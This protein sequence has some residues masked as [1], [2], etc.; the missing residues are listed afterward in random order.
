MVDYEYKDLFWEQHKDKQLRIVSE[1]GSVTLNNTDIHFE[2]F[3]LDESICS[4]ESII[5]GS[6]ESSMVKFRISNVFIPLTGK[7]LI[8]SETIGGHE[9]TPIQIGR[10]KVVSD[11]PTADKSHRDVTAYDEMT[12]ILGKEMA[13]WYNSILPEKESK[14]SMK[15]FRKSFL[16]HFG[17]EEVVPDGGLVNDG[18]IVERTIEPEQISGKDIITSICEIN[19]CFG[20]IG[21]DGKFHYIYLEQNIQGLYPRNDLYPSDTLYP[22]DP[23][24]TR[25]GDG[26]YISCQYEDFLVNSINKLQIRK[27]END[28]GAIIG[29]GDNC[30]IIENNFLVYGKGESELDRIG[31]NIYK[32]ITGIIYRPFSCESIGNPCFE[33]GDPIRISTKRELIETY[34]L[35]RTLRGIQDPRDEYSADGKQK[36]SEDNNSVHKQIIELKGKANILTRTVDETKLEMYDIEKGLFNTITITASEIRTE[37]QNTASGLS[38]RITQ[39]AESITAEVNRATSAEGSLS[40]SIKINADSITSEVRRATSA[41]GTLS[42]SI[43]Q[44]SQSI[45]LR[46]RYDDVVSAINM[47]PEQITIKANKISLEGA[48]TVNGG[49]RIDE[50]GNVALKSQNTE[51]KLRGDMLY[52][53][54]ISTGESALIGTNAISFQVRSGSSIYTRTPIMMSGTTMLIGSSSSQGSFMYINGGIPITS[55]NISQ[56]IPD[57]FSSLT[58]DNLYTSG[59]SDSVG[60][61]ITWLHGQTDALWTRIR[62]VETRLSALESAS[63]G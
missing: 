55:V 30:Y 32:K 15:E 8:V 33:I 6:C 31:N 5:F 14:V 47:S 45:A 10:Y 51:C 36:Y 22:R 3:E 2:Q 39:N 12:E 16:Q 24:T 1:D 20:H 62:S 42:S 34:I 29:S 35:K 13:E 25:I 7:W 54:D 9:E 49:F 60:N 17:I 57:H 48:V 44:N 40:S 58:V 61:R 59:N 4:E 23:K 43:Y 37:L 21:R 41:E 46:V 26:T 38:S 27:E 28:I 52:I 63:A 53:N 18:M 19:G 50:S 11:I 56:Y